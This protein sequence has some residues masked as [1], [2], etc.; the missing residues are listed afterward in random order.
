VSTDRAAEIS[1]L[2]LSTSRVLRRQAHRELEPLGIT[3]SQ[4][5]ALRRVGSAGE[6]MRVSRLAELLGVVPR[7]ATSV[8]DELEHLGAVRRAPDPTDRRAILVSLTRRGE[9][10]LERWSEGRRA[11]MAHLLDRLSARDQRELVRLLRALAEA[12]SSQG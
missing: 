9:H 4:L 7:S 10:I 12:E 6:P 8:L 5:R 2:L 3:P 1:D 11:S